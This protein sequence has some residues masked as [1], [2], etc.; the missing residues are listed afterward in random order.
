L[1]EIFPPYSFFVD[2]PDLPAFLRRIRP[3]L[4]QR[5]A[6]SPLVNYSG[7]IKISFYRAGLRLVFLRGR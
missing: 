1:P 2:V 7:E 4:E 6:T 5:L 3:A